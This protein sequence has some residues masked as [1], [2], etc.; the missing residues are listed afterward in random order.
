MRKTS[1]IADQEFYILE[2]TEQ[3]NDI[4]IADIII[5]LNNNIVPTDVRVI[6]GGSSKYDN[7]DY[8]DTGNI[9]GRPYR[10]GTSMVI[11][12]P[13]RYEPYRNQL[14]QQINKHIS[15][16]EAAIIIFKD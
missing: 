3:S 8:I 14:Q 16:A 1:I 5:K 13:K 10:V 7:Y 9:N 2:D 4:K 6:G 15:S 11:T 12:L